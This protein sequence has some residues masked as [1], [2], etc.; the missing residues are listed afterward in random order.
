MAEAEVLLALLEHLALTA[1]PGVA[2]ALL[3]VRQGT[4]STPVVVG[5]AL[6]SSGVAAMASLWAYYASP[7]VGQACDYLVL[8]GSIEVAVWSW[9]SGRLDRRVLRPLLTPFALWALGGFFIVFLGFL[10]GGANEAV[11]MSA[12]RFSGTLPSDNDI[13]RFFAEWLSH[14]HGSHPPIFP[15]DWLMSDRPPLQIGYVLSQH[16][17]SPTTRELHYEVLCAVVQALWIPA[18]WAVLCAARLRPTTRGLAICAALVSDIAILHGFFVWPKLIATAF[19]LA[20]LALVI[21]PDWPRLRRNPRVGALLGC[22]VALAMLG[23]GSSIF[24]VIPL[25]GIV[26]LRGL[27]SWRWLGASAFVGLA[28]LAP[29]SAFQHYA[30]PPGN[31]LLKWHLA[32]VTE[33]DERGTLEAIVDSYR[34]AGLEGTLDNKW[35]NVTEMT[36]ISRADPELGGAWDSVKAGHVDD[37]LVWLRA[38]RFFALLPC[39]GLLLAAPFAMLLARRRRRSE[40]DW[41]FATYALAIVAIGC[42]F[43]ILLQ[44]GVPGIS[45]TM[46]HAGTLAIPLL[47]ICGCVAGLRA[48]FPRLALAVVGLNAL[49][50]LALYTPSLTPPPGTGYSAVAAVVAVASLLGFGTVAIGDPR[51]RGEPSADEANVAQ[52]TV[53]APGTEPLSRA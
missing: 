24:G 46:I 39:L 6:A 45:S 23:H 37:A 50:V 18:M 15:P 33:V 5:V 21:S 11:R 4:R 7:T 48:T 41:R 51:D 20:A 40:A 26:A 9:W 17:F 14:S 28:L 16:T 47:A 32:G 1:A 43:W 13:P 36:G 44:F 31:R 8:F 10:H 49:L 25:L 12:S 34:E 42:L 52:P 2:A 30:D 38:Y 29:W 19:L 3:V 22:L 35:H 27:P 53:S